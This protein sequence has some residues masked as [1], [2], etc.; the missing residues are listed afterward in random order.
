[1]NS[2]KLSLSP[3]K[4]KDTEVE[5]SM[6]CEVQVTKL[7]VA[8]I[9]AEREVGAMEPPGP[10][11]AMTRSRTRSRSSS[12][13]SVTSYAS[14]ASATA[15]KARKSRRETAWESNRR[16]MATAHEQETGNPVIE[17]ASSSD[18]TDEEK[19]LQ[20]WE[21]SS[22]KRKLESTYGTPDITDETKI[23][24]GRPQTTGYYVSRAQAIEEHNKKKREAAALD[25]ERI[26]RN[27]TTG[28]IYS[29]MERD[30][31]RALDELNDAPTADIAHQARE[32]MA[33]VIKVAKSSKHLQGG[34]IKILKHAAVM[35]SATAE[36]LRTRADGEQDPEDYG[37]ATQLR[38]LKGELERVKREAQQAREEA[39]N[40]KMEADRLRQ[41]LTEIK[42]SRETRGRRRTYIRE[43]S[44]SPSPDRG[45]NEN[46]AEPPRPAKA[47]EERTEES[48]MDVD[49]DVTAEGVPQLPEY[50]DERRKKEILPPRDEWPDALRPPIRGKVKVLE[51]RQLTGT[52]VRL[53][54]MDSHRSEGINTQPASQEAKKGDAQELMRQLAPLLE[55]WLRAN[56]TSM[57][58]QIAGKGG[59]TTAPHKN[60]SQGSQEGGE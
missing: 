1:M 57:G 5:A 20:A 14:S 53:V 16:A 24:Q 2:N 58:V 42:G 36:I 44:S 37:V 11:R 50:S 8:K 3:N 13:S 55:G 26:L 25:N 21:E 33:E 47:P 15:S 12:A 54:K 39:A 10:A 45:R 38:K 35:G 51:D 6:T 52:R 23:K 31:D 28:Q 9:L 17:I 40:A 27:M 4:N 60:G 49:V 41:E 29:K 59:K 30:M 18:G 43:S 48:P 7:D 34:Y 46:R 19:G 56:L 32:C 22:R